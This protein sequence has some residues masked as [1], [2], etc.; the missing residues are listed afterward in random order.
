MDIDLKVLESRGR[1]A[2]RCTSEEQAKMFM[3]AMWEQ[4][5]DKVRGI[6]NRGQTNWIG[7]GYD[8]LGEICYKHRIGARENLEVS[9]CQSG[10]VRGARQEGYIIIDFDELISCHDYGEFDV[11]G[12]SACDLLETMQYHDQF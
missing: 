8:E 12:F 5:P 9:Y 1:S 10:Y 7:Y 6:W 11:S 3:E 4:Y 2:V